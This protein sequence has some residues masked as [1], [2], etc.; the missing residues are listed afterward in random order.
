M[1]IWYLQIQ[2]V[3]Q[4][5]LS[6]SRKLMNIKDSRASKKAENVD[7]TFTEGIKGPNLLTPVPEPGQ[8]T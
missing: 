1:V 3:L 7:H 6:P 4:F 5:L 8:S 2:E